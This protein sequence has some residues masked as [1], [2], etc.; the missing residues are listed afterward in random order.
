MLTRIL[1]NSRRI[2]AILDANRQ[3]LNANERVTLEQFRQHIDDLEAYHLEDTRED[4]SRFPS[5][6]TKILED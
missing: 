3:L 1:P 2:L 5:A 4:A 6:M